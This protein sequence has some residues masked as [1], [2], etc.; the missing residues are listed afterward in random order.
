MYRVFEHRTPLRTASVVDS[1]NQLR[2]HVNR[3]RAVA[4]DDDRLYALRVCSSEF[5]TNAIKYGGQHADEKADLLIVGEI[6]TR[7]SRLRIT[8]TD[9]RSTVPDMGSR[10]E[11]LNATGGRGITV[12]EGYA[13]EAGWY[14]RRDNAGRVSGWSVWFELDVQLMETFG[15]ATAVEAEAQPNVVLRRVGVVQEADAAALARRAWPGCVGWPSGGRDTQSS[16]RRSK[17]SSVRS[18][19]CS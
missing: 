11:D 14:Q 13:D 7:R 9:P 10:A 3:L 18:T 12:V 2:D 4:L 15:Q 8:V 19:R 1:R 16:L 17:A 6:D 5:V